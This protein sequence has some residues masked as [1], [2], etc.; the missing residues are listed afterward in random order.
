MLFHKNF[1]KT[2]GSNIKR[3]RTEQGIT[4]KDL[5]EELDMNIQSVSQLERG[6]YKPSIEKLVEISEILNVTPN[7]IL[8]KDYE[9]LKWKKE[10]FTEL[11][12]SITGVVDEMNIVED[13]RAKAILA[14]GSGDEDSERFYLDQIIGIYAWR[15]EHY[16]RIAD[17]LYYQRLDELIKKTSNEMIKNKS[18]NLK[19]LNKDKQK[20]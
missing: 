14:K 1:D 19:I 15:N 5:A 11:D 3:L 16:W 6:I 18:D 7:D 4:Q 20:N 9:Y 8:L 17:F 13:I 12:Y 2:I 10:R